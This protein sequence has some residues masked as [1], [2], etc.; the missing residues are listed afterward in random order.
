MAILA[1]DVRTLHDYAEGVMHRAGHHARQVSAIVLAIL[2]GIIWRVEPGSI[3]I[4]QYDGDLAN[5]LW[6]A[7]SAT[8]NRYA[9]AYNHHTGEVE[10]RDR[11]M[12]GRV[13]HSFTNGTPI[14]D[15]ERVFSSL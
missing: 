14:T 9:C 4:K 11:N 13:L 15:V 10:I 7:S 8:R 6:W 5:V 3:E 12:R 1:D 2:G